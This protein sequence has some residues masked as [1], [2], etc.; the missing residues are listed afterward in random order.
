MAASTA[1]DCMPV[2]AS[3]CT[4]RARTAAESRPMPEGCCGTRAPAGASAERAGAAREAG[5]GVCTERATH[6]GTPGRR[7]LTV[8]PPRPDRKSTRLNSSHLVI[9]YA[10]FCLKKKKNLYHESVRRGHMSRPTQPS[11]CHGVA[12]VSPA[13]SPRPAPLLDS[14]SLH[15]ALQDLSRDSA[16]T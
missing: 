8:A 1:G 13:P 15:S 4:M 5:A 6:E 12:R 14:L 3:R 11:Q 16:F 9:S 10:V 2:A 7:S